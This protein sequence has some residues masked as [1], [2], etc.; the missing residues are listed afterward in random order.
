MIKQNVMDTVELVRVLHD[1]VRNFSLQ[2]NRVEVDL[3]DTQVEI[4]KQARHSAAIREIEMAIV[5]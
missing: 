3:L 5:E 4:T 2:L 1:S